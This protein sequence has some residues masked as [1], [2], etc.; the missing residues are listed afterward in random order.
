MEAEILRFPPSAR[1]ERLERELEQARRERDSAIRRLR[2]VQ[3]DLEELA[4][5][6]RIKRAVEDAAVVAAV[7]A[8]GFVAGLLAVWILS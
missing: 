6:R 2:S 3:A 1:I 5:Y 4:R 7:V 8:V